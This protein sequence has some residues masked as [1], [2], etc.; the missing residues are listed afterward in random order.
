MRSLLRLMRSGPAA[1][2][3]AGIGAQALNFV[4]GWLIA[5][6]LGPTGRGNTALVA[7]YD[8]ASTIALSLGVPAAVGREASQ[9][10][11]D[12]RSTV[13]ARLL[14]SA[15]TIAVFVTPAAALLS[16]L[17]FTFA[18]DGAPRSIQFLVVAAI[19]ATPIVNTVPMAGRMILTARGELHALASLIM[20]QMV[21]RLAIYGL[22]ILFDAFTA[23]TAALG[24]L[25]SGWFGSILVWFVVGIRPTRGGE[26]GPL[27]RFGVKTVP[28]SM[29]D[30]TNSRLDQL[31]IVPLLSTRD[32]GIYAVAIGVAFLPINIGSSMALSAYRVAARDGVDRSATRQ[33]VRRGVRL[34]AAAGL[35][36]ALGA[37][38]LLVPVYGSE[39]ADSIV[40]AMLLVGGSVATGITAILVQ[41]ANASGRPLIGSWSSLAG[42]IVTL[43]GL[44]IVLPTFGV[45]GA[46]VVSLLAYSTR[47][48][49]A[50]ILTRPLRRG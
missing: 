43:V 29:A 3:S 49:V 34:V 18:L 45:V 8:D 22:L 46:A 15:L 17:V 24:F 2:V 20:I 12:A 4:G 41:V 21:V 11:D 16:W 14:G 40:P 5:R 47:C 39:F 7:V 26:L 23:T 38:F 42:L 27:L 48:L 30:L 9:A 13:E 28:G 6:S 44:P 35:V 1:L 32:L 19:A 36:S 10:D 25:A 33:A 50:T 31:L 37:A